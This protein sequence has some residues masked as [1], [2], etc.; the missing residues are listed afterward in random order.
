MKMISKLL[1]GF[2][3]QLL[4][5]TTGVSSLIDCSKLPDSR[6]ELINASFVETSRPLNSPEKPHREGSNNNN[7]IGDTAAEDGKERALC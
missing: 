3:I 2:R 1:Q 5:V 7:D 4:H 6:L